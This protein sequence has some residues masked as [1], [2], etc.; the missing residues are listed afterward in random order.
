MYVHRLIAMAFLGLDLDS[1]LQ[2][3]HKNGVKSFNAVSN[4]ELCTFSEN[5]IHRTSLY[6]PH[7]TDT[8]KECRMCR[9]IKDRSLFVKRGSDVGSYCK[10]CFREYMKNRRK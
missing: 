4:L 7:D 3:N 10:Q 6:H 5:L 8:H 1:E 2:V 9:V